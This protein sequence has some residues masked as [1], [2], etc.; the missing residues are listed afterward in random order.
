MI[1]RIQSL[2]LLLASVCVGL[3]FF[4]PYAGFVRNGDQFNLLVTGVYEAKGALASHPVNP[5]PTIILTALCV[6]LPIYI[7][8]LYRK[9]MNQIKLSRLCIFLNSGLLVMMFVWMDKLALSIS[10]S[11]K[12]YQ[13]GFAFP[14]LAIIFL[15]LAIRGVKKDEAL[16]RSADRIR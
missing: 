2:F 4:L 6:L 10:N 3:L 5:L 7:I 13:L 8:F 9:R 15:F 14:V 16:I 11:V 12:S 1:Q